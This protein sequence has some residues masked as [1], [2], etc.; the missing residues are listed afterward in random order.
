MQADTTWTSSVAIS[1]STPS[2]I[3]KHPTWVIVS[4][5]DPTLLRGEMVWWTKLNFLGQHT[6]LR[7]CNLATFKTFAAN[8][9]K[10]VQILKWKWTNFSV[11]REVLCNNYWY[12]SLIGLYRFWLISPRNLTSFTSRFLPY[13]CLATS[14]PGLLTSSFAYRRWSKTGHGEGLG[15]RLNLLAY[16]KLWSMELDSSSDNVE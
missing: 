6:L 3:V 9:L 8:P 1:C 13:F 5:P 11:G 10:K 14:F 16:F 15:T 7:Q 4:S 2:S 12:R